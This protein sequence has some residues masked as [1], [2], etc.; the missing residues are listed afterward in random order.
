MSVSYGLNPE[1]CEY[2]DIEKRGN[3]SVFRA[4]FKSLSQLHLFLNSNPEVNTNI[5]YNQKSIKAPVEFAGEELPVAIEYCLGGYEKDFSMFVRLKK[6]LD[7]V[8]VRH[9]RSRKTIPSM[10]GFRPNVPAFVAGAPKTMYRMERVKEKKFI[11][12]YF[13]LAYSNNTTEEQVRNRGILTLNLIKILENNDYGVSLKVFE[14]SMVGNEVF[15][16]TIGISR[17]GQ[18]LD[19]KKCYYPLCGRE[20]LR[21]ITSRIKESMPFKENWH[22]GYG[23]LLSDK[24]TR[25]IMNIPR[26]GIM[27]NS[28][29]IMGIKGQDIYEDADNFLAKLN[30]DKSIVVPDYV[31]ESKEEEN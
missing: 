31:K 30:L 13:N 29:D 3:L 14:T 4:D 8:T 6:D 27:I 1:Q 21:R 26:D 25:L 12:I 7:R 20:F 9:V 2:L 23:S 22:M 19:V 24:E 17:P 16:T 11:T 28:P 5:F 10:V 18:L 15:V